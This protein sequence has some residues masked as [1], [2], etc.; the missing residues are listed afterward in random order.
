[1]ADEE[2]LLVKAA[3]KIGQVAGK[4][5]SLGKSAEPETKR[6]KPAHSGKLQKKNKSRLPRKL[7]KERKKA[8]AAAAKG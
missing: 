6:A 1:M 4:V 7:K 3:K 5:A 2:S 8:A